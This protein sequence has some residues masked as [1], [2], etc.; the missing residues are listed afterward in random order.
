[1]LYVY[2]ILYFYIIVHI[3]MLKKYDDL[4]DGRI[5][6]TVKEKWYFNW[7]DFA[8]PLEESGNYLPQEEYQKLISNKTDTNGA[9]LSV[10]TIPVVISEI[11]WVKNMKFENGNA[12]EEVVNYIS[13]KIITIVES[14]PS[15]SMKSLKEYKTAISVALKFF[16][17]FFVECDEW[18]RNK[19]FWDLENLQEEI[20]F[21]VDAG[22]DSFMQDKSI[23]DKE[24][25]ISEKLDQIDE[26]INKFMESLPRDAI[27]KIARWAF[28]DI[29]ELSDQ[30]LYN[31]LSPEN[32]E[33]SEDQ[34]SDTNLTYDQKFRK[35]LLKL[36]E[37]LDDVYKYE[38]W[39]ELNTDM[40]DQLSIKRLYD[41]LLVLIKKVKWWEYIN[42][43]CPLQEYIKT[44]LKS[45]ETEDAFDLQSLSTII[46]QLKESFED[47]LDESGIHPRSFLY[48]KLLELSQEIDQSDESISHLWESVRI[49]YDKL[50]SLWDSIDIGLR[51]K[52]IE[53]DKKI[54]NFW[55]KD[56]L[57]QDDPSDAIFE[58][59]N[60]IVNNF[61]LDSDVQVK[62]SI[63]IEHIFTA[64]GHIYFS[65]KYFKDT[66]LPYE[67]IFLPKKEK[68]INISNL[69]AKDLF[70]KIIIYKKELD[71]NSVDSNS[72]ENLLSTIDCLKKCSDEELIKLLS[73]EDLWNLENIL[74]LEKIEDFEFAVR[75]RDSIILY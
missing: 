38:K 45:Y 47:L 31:K 40:F 52:V 48:N 22:I 11:N 29:E 34:E 41:K 54:S 6:Y 72:L 26:V 59:L 10:F 63:T 50:Q 27:R 65:E 39:D 57:E 46:N 49:F 1:M 66:L 73:K 15:E 16:E 2:I 7:K 74:S 32:Q 4:E 28:K 25:I 37:E 18:D 75:I 51:K 20:C 5:Y 12:Q 23:E 19:I 60:D 53:L 69:S 14:T 9:L 30:Y 44:F 68:K 8:Y 42:F 33:L 64:F 56:I 3:S 21:I 24:S 61:F 70:D 35:T 43:L 17:C 55:K 13:W 71:E 67:E 58:K 36:Y 62:Y